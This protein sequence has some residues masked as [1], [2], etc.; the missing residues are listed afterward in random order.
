MNPQTHCAAQS[1]AK[2]PICNTGLR[3]TWPD[4][5][6]QSEKIHNEDLSPS[7]R[8]RLDQGHACSH[9]K[10]GLTFIEWTAPFSP[11]LTL[12]VL[13][14]K[15]S[16]PQNNSYPVLKAWVLL[17]KKFNLHFL[18]WKSPLLQW[19]VIQSWV[20]T[21]IWP[22]IFRNVTTQFWA[23]RKR[24]W[25]LRTESVLCGSWLTIHN[26]AGCWGQSSSTRRWSQHPK[27]LTVAT[28]IVLV[29]GSYGCSRCHLHKERRK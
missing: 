12:L 23:R 9:K 11:P 3:W 2:F 5:F 15:F 19:W 26:A 20:C 14:I 18:T 28:L 6:E 7:N 8:D 4:S 1:I 22:N 25:P 10:T 13:C 21:S 16:L 24:S 27:R 17:S 29:G